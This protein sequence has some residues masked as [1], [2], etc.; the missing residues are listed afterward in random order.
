MSRRALVTFLL[1]APLLSA[2]GSDIARRVPGAQVSTSTAD[3]SEAAA[4]ISRYRIARGLSPVSADARLN[5]AAEVQARAVAETGELSHGAFATRMASFGVGGVSAENLS[6]GSRTVAQAVAR[7]QASPRHNDNLLMPE[8]RHVGLARA[9][10][11]GA[12]YGRYWALVL[13]Q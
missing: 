1:A 9:D 13:A 6:A 2:C 4:L 12:G 10:S 3:A 8:A 7:W 5:R 11:P